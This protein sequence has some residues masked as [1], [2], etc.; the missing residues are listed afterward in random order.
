MRPGRFSMRL[1]AESRSMEGS[2]GWL[3]GWDWHP[4]AESTLIMAGDVAE[5]V[6]GTMF[7]RMHR[8]SG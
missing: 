6:D 2:M 7:G 4:R 3:T 1:I 5:Q 8:L